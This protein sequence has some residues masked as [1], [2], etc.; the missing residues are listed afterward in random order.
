MVDSQRVFDGMVQHDGVSWNSLIQGY[1]TNGEMPRALGILSLMI[2]ESEKSSSVIPTPRTFVA[3]LKGCSKLA[4][5]EDG[6]LVN[7]KLVKVSSLQKVSEIHLVAAKYGRTDSTSVFVGNSL[8]DLYAKCGSLEDA[9]R[10]FDRM[11]HRDRVSWNV[12]MAGCAFH[13]EEEASLELFERMLLQGYA[14]N[15][16]SFVTALKACSSLAEKEEAIKG[17]RDGQF[18]K[19][20]ALEKAMA[21]HSQA[22][23]LGLD[24]YMA[25]AV[26]SLYA[27]CGS[28]VNGLKVFDR[29]LC[30]DLVMWNTMIL[31]CAENHD[32]ELSL[33]LFEAMS[34]HSCEA[35]NARTL[36]A[37]LKACV[38]LAEKEE[39][40]QE[41]SC[42]LVEL[43]SKSGSLVDSMA[44]F[45]AMAHDPDV[46]LWTALI[47]G[48]ADNGE[49]D[50]ALELF[51]QMQSHGG[52]APDAHSFV[53]AIRAC[54]SSLAAAKES[55]ETKVL[56]CMERGMALHIEA[57][58]Q[59][60]V[61]NKFLASALVDMYV[62]CSSMDDARRVFAAIQRP[63][64]AT[65]N[66]LLLGYVE[67]GQ[68]E[69]ALETY[70]QMKARGGLEPNA[71]TLGLALRACGVARR[72]ETGKRVHGELCRRGLESDAV[73]AT[74]LIDF[75]A[76]FGSLDNSRQVFDLVS[77]RD[78]ITWNA[79]IAGWS[80]Q[81]SYTNSLALFYAMQDEDLR[82]S[83][84]T[85]VS[86]LNA[87]S[88]AGMVER[89]RK[90]FRAMEESSKFAVTP[91]IEHYG[92]MIAVLCRANQ[93]DDAVAMVRG[94]PVEANAVAW[95][96]I[97]NECWKRQNLVVGALAFD[98]LQRMGF[99]TSSAF[100]LMT[101]TEGAGQSL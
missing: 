3:A 26:I 13:G 41:I 28:I 27:R 46:T 49:E 10:V 90:I 30:R 101:R 96:I 15:S 34:K 100:T 53:A 86:L 69:L 65:W 92:C 73:L 39:E 22:E 83:S 25:S 78:V 17:S 56:V 8:V 71:S 81:G 32:A 16:R 31:G 62:R 11:D 74:S 1:A 66:T 99:T 80:S 97:L 36:V 5:E 85:F 57:T 20:V 87:C 98:A 50:L 14:A 75:Y 59:G 44:V 9:R 95:T 54:G 72:L 88:H 76:K 2:W 48:C 35:P 45:E 61:S 89:A 67:S 70:E 18:V 84:V 23:R 58:K 24:V 77:T 51:S 42:A 38:Y 21:I 29:M 93:L 55:R 82:P 79:L 43:Y 12:L 63:E 4:V 6:R 37:V 40:A 64:V 52:C 7:G 47:T 68:G 91:G 19:I 33:E 60:F 94:M